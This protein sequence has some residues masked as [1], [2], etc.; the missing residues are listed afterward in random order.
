M[1]GARPLRTD[2]EEPIEPPAGTGEGPAAADAPIRFGRPRL[3]AIPAASRPAGILEPLIVVAVTLIMAGIVWAVIRGLGF[4][5][6]GPIDVA[7]D[8]DQPPVLLILVG[9][10]LTYRSRR[11]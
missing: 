11:R 9:A 5:G 6:V 3:R 4:Y 7:Y 1:A 10:W 8:L 2:R